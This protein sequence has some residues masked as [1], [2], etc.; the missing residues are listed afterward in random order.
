MEGLTHDE[1]RNKLYLAISYQENSMNNRW[2]LFLA[3]WISGWLTWQHRLQTWCKCWSLMLPF[4]SQLH[5][6]QV[7]DNYCGCVYAIDLDADYSAYAISPQVR[8]LQSLTLANQGSRLAIFALRITAISAQPSMDSLTFMVHTCLYS[9]G[10]WDW[11]HNSSW[12]WHR[13]GKCHELWPLQAI[14]PRQSQH[15]AGKSCALCP[16]KVDLG[17]S[18][19]MQSACKGKKRVVKL[20]T[21]P[22]PSVDHRTPLGWL[23]LRTRATEHKTF[24]WCTMWVMCIHKWESTRGG[25]LRPKWA[26]FNMRFGS[27][28]GYWASSNFWY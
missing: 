15:D 10:V 22:H 27:C 11:E 25:Q 28:A 1:H 12:D 23:S 2:V 6:I 16:A 26:C 13:H 20:T 19:L 7:Q 9:A 17:Q 18:S 24:S 8:T 5:D 21:L 4:R 3:L 14:Q